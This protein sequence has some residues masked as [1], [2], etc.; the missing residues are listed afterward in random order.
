MI[1]QVRG[2]NGDRKACEAGRFH[3]WESTSEG[4]NELDLFFSAIDNV[5][6]DPTPP[7]NRS[8]GSKMTQRTNE[9]RV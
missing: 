6:V 4:T 9:E 7:F 8:N 1:D 2:T 5:L 3:L